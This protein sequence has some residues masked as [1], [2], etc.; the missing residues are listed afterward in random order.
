M[1]Q[2][3]LLGLTVWWLGF[4][5]VHHMG[6]NM[7]SRA[8]IIFCCRSAAYD[9]ADSYARETGVNWVVISKG[10]KFMPIPDMSFLQADEE[11]WSFDIVGYDSQ[12]EARTA[13][14]NM[15]CRIVNQARKI[16]MEAHG[17]QKY[18]DGL[19]VIHLDHVADILRGYNYRY[20]VAA[21]LH[22]TLEDTELSIGELASTFTRN[23]AA[24]IDLVSDPDGLTRD[25]RKL[26][27][28]LKL[29]AASDHLALTVKAADRLANMRQTDRDNDLRRKIMYS[30]EAADFESAVRRT[31][32]CPEIW[33][34][35]DNIRSKWLEEIQVLRRMRLVIN[36]STYGSGGATTKVRKN[37][38]YGQ[39]SKNADV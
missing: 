27:S 6:A 38:M 23:M 24:T 3:Y 39:F 25:A 22:D 9:A 15:T 13:F 18:G 30:Q 36:H 2:S 16:A 28:H 19:Y 11:G 20:R 7:N 34:E 8:P 32:L 21:Y 4:Y 12:H 5:N 29:R 17:D 10:D 14:D 37:S 26:L 1:E 35:I 33:A 31:G